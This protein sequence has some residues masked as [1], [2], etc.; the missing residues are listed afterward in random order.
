[1]LV[2]ISTYILRIFK[3]PKISKLFKRVYNKLFM[4]F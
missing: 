1:M 4:N 2:N 3:I